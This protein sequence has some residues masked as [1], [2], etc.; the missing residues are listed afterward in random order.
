MVY[1]QKSFLPV[2]CLSEPIEEIG[3]PVLRD[4]LRQHPSDFVYFE[5]GQKLYG[6]ISMGDITRACANEKQSVTINTACSR[7]KK[8]DY[9]LARKL[10]LNNVRL[11]ALPVVD[12]SGALLGSFSRFDDLLFLKYWNGWDHC[13]FI[14]RYAGRKQR[15]ALVQPVSP[16]PECSR[17]FEIWFEKLSSKGFHCEK[18][19]PDQVPD[20][21]EC[22]DLVLFTDEDQRRGARAVFLM[23]GRFNYDK[24]RTL[25]F[26]DM[27][28]AMCEAPAEDIFLDLQSRGIKVLM[29]SMEW[30]D[31]EYQKE[32]L[33]YFCERSERCGNDLEYVHPEEAPLFYGSFYSEEYARNVGKHMFLTEKQVSHTRLK[34]CNDQYFHISEG[35]RLTV[36]QPENAGSSI[37]FF[38]PCACIGPYVEDRHT[39]ESFLQQILNDEGYLYRVVNYGCWEDPYSEL[40]HITSTPMKKGDVAVV[41]FEGRG[42]PSVEN[43]DLLQVLEENRVPGEWMLNLPAHANA[44]V[45]RLYAEAIFNRLKDGVLNRKTGSADL[46]PQKKRVLFPRRIAVEYLYLDRYFW[47]LPPAKGERIANIGI[48]GNPFTRGHLHLA[49]TALAHSDRLIVLVLEEELSLFDFTERY[50]MACAALK[51]LGDVIVVPSGPFLGTRVTNPAYYTKDETNMEENA[52]NEFR[53]FGTLIAPALEITTCYL[54][55]EPLNPTMTRF[56]QI[57][58]DVLG[59]CGIETIVIPRKELND[60]PVSASVVRQLHS[61]QMEELEALVPP[62]TLE[63]ILGVSL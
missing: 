27:T 38:G 26:R 63:I 22:F 19:T 14:S 5:Y 39:I 25:T 12:D 17:Q 1:I 21:Y 51:D 57:V 47:K 8:D 35:E 18:I 3:F 46:S 55:E 6:L 15:I 2:V 52:E 20:A 37:F 28:R 45:H 31:S 62:T 48:N 11:H 40:I 36:G 9:I 59:K 34:D 50:A 41:F 43:V 24:E 30:T 7:V 13:R 53:V 49:K 4:A 16:S 56:N 29:L 61:D 32:L 58:E 10:F 44:C 23:E 60:T 54:G 33:R 42:F